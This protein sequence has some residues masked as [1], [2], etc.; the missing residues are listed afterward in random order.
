MANIL[1]DLIPSLQAT[2]Q[3]VVRESTPINMV[4]DT[5][6]GVEAAALGQTVTVVSSAAVTGVDNTPGATHPGVGDVAASGIEVGI[7]K[8]RFWG[9]RLNGEEYKSMA[10]NGPRFQSEQVAEAIRT[11]INEVWEDIA[12]LYG[13]GS[14]AW[15]TPGSNPFA[16]NAD[17]LWDVKTLLD[18]ASAPASGRSVILDPTAYNNLGKLN[19]IQNVSSAGSTE[20]LREGVISKLAG[21]PLGMATTMRTHTKG[22]GAGYLVNNVAGYPIG[23]KAIV[24]D[25]GTGTIVA[26]DF[27]TFAGDTNK[28]IATG[29]SGSTLTLNTGLKQAVADNTAITVGNSGIR[30]LVG[31]KSA[32]AFG[33]RPPAQPPEGDAAADRVIIRDPLTGIAMSFAVYKQFGQVI[34]QAEL[35]WGGKVVRPN[36]LTNLL[37]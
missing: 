6:Y 17:A 9:F 8:S 10:Q 29:L 34:Y 27:V 14:L 5:S 7:T 18:N 13:Q 31:H 15:G 26:G 16:S 32:I 2:L 12:A 4:V 20:T 28:Y 11:G 25:T 24:V 36:W 21:M 33:M 1:T 37:A 30:Y 19:L 22:T 35:A 3:S 23:A